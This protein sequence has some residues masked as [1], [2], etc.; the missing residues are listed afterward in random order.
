M[1]VAAQTQVYDF[2]D[3]ADPWA[4]LEAVNKDELAGHQYTIQVCVLRVCV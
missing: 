4:V 3:S 1:A 2:P